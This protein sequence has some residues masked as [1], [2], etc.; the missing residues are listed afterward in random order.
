MKKL[1]LSN[2]F[3]NLNCEVMNTGFGAYKGAEGEEKL[4]LKFVVLAYIRNSHAMGTS[5]E[6]QTLAYQIGCKVGVATDL[7]ELSNAEW[8]LLKKIVDKNKIKQSN[9]QEEVYFG[10]EVSQQA[11][12]LIDE[13][14]NIEENKDKK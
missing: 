3:K 13:A 7:I 8:T 9:G 10:L 14:E 2:V 11:K 5:Q 12:Q 1:N 4:T 6:E